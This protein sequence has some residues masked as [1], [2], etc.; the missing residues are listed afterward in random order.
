MKALVQG[1]VFLV[2]AGFVLGGYLWYDYRRS[3]QPGFMSR[4]AQECAGLYRRARDRA[5][6]ARVDLVHPATAEQ[7]DSNAPTCGTMRRAGS[8]PAAA[9][10]RSED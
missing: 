1:L 5:D 2:F 7:R 8:V 9:P 10:R 3:R 4:G 6:T